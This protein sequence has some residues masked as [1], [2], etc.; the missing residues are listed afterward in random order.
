MAIP[1]RSIHHLHIV[2]ARAWGG[3]ESYVYN[4]TKYAIS[5][6]E[7]VTI[8]TDVDSPSVT[9]RFSELTKV[10]SLPL[11]WPFFFSN[12]RFLSKYI[13]TE[14]V[15]VLNYH[16]GKIAL[17]SVLSAMC[18]N[19]PCVFFKHNI[20]HG[21]SD[22]YHRFIYRHLAAIICVSE[23]VKQSFLNGMPEAFFNRVHCV[24][25]GLNFQPESLQKIA[26]EGIRIGYAGRL[27]ENKGIKVL[28]EAF[29]QIKG[30]QLSLLI[31]G[32]CCTPEAQALCNQT[33]DPRIRFIG[34][35]KDLSD[36][37]NSLDIFVAP[38]IVPEAFGLSLCEAMGHSLAVIST[39][40]GAQAEV[41]SNNEN[42]LLVEPGSVSSLKKA[43]ENLIYDPA[44]RQIMGER[45]EERI[46][47]DFSMD[48]FYSGL[49]R[50][51]DFVVTR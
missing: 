18:G 2:S 40:S 19:I 29:T 39:T 7:R 37:Y 36:F 28:I 48:R 49:S 6:G 26:H 35:K 32:N 45:A 42:G 15:D 20:T 41:I 10:Y 12:I 31:A 34:E 11:S 47:N 44:L 46:R 38:S 8:V 21:K 22:L 30:D 33:E 14:Q 9:Q 50:I 17:L 1:K 23:T 25:T 51:Y 27:V 16:S 43:L 24:L 3:G 13:Q 4:L 5:K